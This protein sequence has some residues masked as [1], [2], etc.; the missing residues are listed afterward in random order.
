MK[1]GKQKTGR[2]QLKWED[3]VKWDVR[4]TEWEDEQR[5]KA[6]GREEGKWTTAGAAVQELASP[7]YKYNMILP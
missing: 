7:V 4:K 1:Y 2:Q 5:E 6:A 3:C